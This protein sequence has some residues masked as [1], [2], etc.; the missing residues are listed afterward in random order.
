MK[1][2]NEKERKQENEYLEAEDMETGR[3]EKE[4]GVDLDDEI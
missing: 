1:K 2:M 3:D 4:T